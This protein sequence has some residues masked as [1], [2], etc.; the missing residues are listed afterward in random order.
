MIAEDQGLEENQ[1]RT[2]QLREKRAQAQDARDRDR[3]R[4]LHGEKLVAVVAKATSKALSLDDFDSK[5]ESLPIDWPADIRDARGL[6][7]A[8]IS[9]SD[10][11]K[12]LACVRERAGAFSGK[13]GFHERPYLGFAAMHGVDPVSLLVIAQSTEDSVIFYNDAPAGIVLVDCYTSQPSE[14]FSIVVQGDGLVQMLAPCFRAGDSIP[15][16]AGP[17]P[18]LPSSKPPFGCAK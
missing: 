6:V 14:P 11:N 5:D 16:L 18:E 9:G 2:N 17:S 4:E 8:Y 1:A 12:L 13:I 7:A 10:A 15:D 3:L